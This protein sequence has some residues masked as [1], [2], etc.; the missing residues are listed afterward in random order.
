[1]WYSVVRCIE[2][3]PPGWY[4][5][6]KGALWGNAGEKKKGVIEI[7]LQDV[8]RNPYVWAF[9]ISYFFVY[10]V[11]QGVTSW[12][13]FYLKVR[14]HTHLPSPATLVGESL[15]LCSFWV[16]SCGTVGPPQLSGARLIRGG[17]ALGKGPRE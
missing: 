11:R 10:V 13:V 7:L 9:A 1:V 3:A 5:V 12:F 2:G 4:S 15:P 6:S 8:L 16:R 14:S 17:T